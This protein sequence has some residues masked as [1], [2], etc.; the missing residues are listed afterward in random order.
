MQLEV[1][2]LDGL[3]KKFNRLSNDSQKRV[4]SA[5]QS[6]ADNVASDAKRLVPVD[7]GNLKNSIN[8]KYGNGFA[9]VTASAN[10]AAYVEFGTRKMASEYVSSLPADWVSYA[11]TFKRSRGKITEGMR[12]RPF[13]Y[14]AVNKNMLQLIQD[15]KDALK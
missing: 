13:M 6:W 10:Y 9:S 1:K 15:I 12:P 8:P 14:P 3:I 4:N 5:L 7:T 2:G 11:A